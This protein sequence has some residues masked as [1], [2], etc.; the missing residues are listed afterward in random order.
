MMTYLNA[1]PKESSMGQNGSMNNWHQLQVDM[2]S[3]FQYGMAIGNYQYTE[4]AL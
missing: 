4:L 1:C 3:F 2:E